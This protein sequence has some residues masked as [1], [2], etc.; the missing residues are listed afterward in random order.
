M[1]PVSFPIRELKFPS[2]L[3]VVA[4][5]DARAPLVGLFLVVG[6]G[7]TSDPVGKEGVAHYVEHLTFR[8]RPFEKA[9]FR[10][11]LSRAG[12]GRWNASTGFDD[13][14]Y[15]EIGA[16]SALPQLLRLEGI[17]MLA[18]IANVPP[19]TFAV[20]LEVVKNELRQRN[21]T[22]F[23][24]EVLGSLQ[25]LVFPPSHPYARPV[26]GTRASLSAIQPE[27]VVSFLRAHYRPDNMTLLVI[28]DVDLDAIQRIAQQNLPTEM[29]AATAPVP[30]ARRMPERAPEPPAP[31]ASALVRKQA[32]VATPELWIGWSLPRAFDA[33]AHTMILVTDAMDAEL[34]GA[35]REDGDIA[36]VST[37]LVPGQQASMYVC[38]VVLHQGAHPERSLEHV[39][40]RLHRVWTDN[41]D[42]TGSQGESYT[43][44]VRKRSAVVDLLLEAEDLRRHG[45]QRALS[46]H[47][48]QDVALYGRATASVTALEQNRVVDYAQ[49]YL[50]RERARAALFSPPAGEGAQPEARSIETAPDDADPLPISL[51]A[52][53]LR[54][55]APA[56]AIESYRQ[57]TLP[58]G[59]RV[60]IGRHDGLPL[61][62]VGL[63]FHGGVAGADDPATA[64]AAMMLAGP[65][66]KR[67]G[68][69]DV[70]GGRMHRYDRTNGVDYI[71]EGAAGN[72][73]IMLAIVAERLQSMT[74]DPGRLDA[75]RR[76][77]LPYLQRADQKPELA[78]ERAFRSA[79]LAG[80]PYG[81]PATA[82]A[83]GSL[84][85]SALQQWIDVTY[86]PR[87]AVLSVV[88]EIDPGEVER[89]VVEQ[90]GA[91]KAANGDWPAPVA[92]GP[93]PDAAAR[94][95]LV[96]THW[97][98]A[99]QA[100]IRFGCLLPPARTPAIAVR[101]DL[102]AAL[103][104]ARLNDKI[105][106]E[107]GISY[108]VGV[109]ARMVRGGTAYLELRGAVVSGQLDATL[110]VLRDALAQ[111]ASAPASDH[112]IAWQ[113][114]EVAQSMS[115][116]YMTNT[117]IVRALLSSANVGFP[118][119]TIVELPDDLSAATAAGVQEDFQRCTA[120]R[121]TLSIV[122]PEAAARDAFTKAWP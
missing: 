90:F 81:R 113:K 44:A 120:G 24:G 38:R 98:A 27:D 110:V 23:T 3:R 43:L 100:Q 119:K 6:A 26:I 48:A 101:H 104:E 22:S 59:L 25:A 115:L 58:N 92:L 61:A 35:E 108:G 85:A 51:D 94:P 28:G 83:M 46:A 1:R 53:R 76:D 7:S 67:H 32:A 41:P 103:L 15:Y 75:F 56:P 50:T 18:P 2:G 78:A 11:L 49:R 13:T 96:T 57:L 72:V 64:R 29:L 21:E 105:R 70:F 71:L 80:H 17:R 62:S 88:G 118:P 55:V 12:A 68:A 33:D 66:V 122:G 82:D 102:A 69:P 34:G 39:V 91:W 79:L 45:T 63:T 14:V 60:V 10:R 109:E 16:S 93:G 19:A 31:P 112:L 86:T 84:G 5:R 65:R 47:F 54:S 106:E 4:Q 73:G 77:F 74:V 107:L 121:P 87:N 111:L 97:P 36:S 8:S 99:T 89:I 20:E 114:L 117:G 116:N 42:A 95:S 9:S 52:Q 40:N 37:A 30:V